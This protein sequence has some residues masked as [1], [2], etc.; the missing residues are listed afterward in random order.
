[1][2]SS[3]N[4][5]LSLILMTNPML[6]CC[7]Y[8]SSCHRTSSDAKYWTIC[9]IFIAMT[10]LWLEE[11]ASA[12]EFPMIQCSCGFFHRAEIIIEHQAEIIIVK[13]LI[14]GR[15][16]ET[17]VRVEP[18]LC[19]Q[20]RRKKT[21]LPSRPRCRCILSSRQIQIRVRLQIRLKLFIFII[22]YWLA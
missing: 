5:T 21:L 17:R 19:D 3:K 15:N 7:A 2:F 1:M 22:L 20:D 16:N 14:Q 9:A 18:R 13:R 6:C 11:S 4:Q 10:T 8:V 12:Q